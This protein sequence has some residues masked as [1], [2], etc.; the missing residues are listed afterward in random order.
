MNLA[1]DGSLGAPPRTP[2]GGAPPPGPRHNFLFLHGWGFDALVWDGVRARLGGVAPDLG[3]LGAPVPAPAE[4]DAR[5]IAVGHSLGCL[6]LLGA[7]P[8]GCVG[9][10]AVNGFSRFC[11]APDFPNGVPTRLLERMLA[12]LET[13]PYAVLAEFRHRC[14]APPL[15]AGSALDAD[16][17]ERLRAGLLALR[18]RDE[19]AAA[20]ALAVPMLVLAGEADPI[21]PPALTQASFPGRTI[22]WRAGGGHLLPL[23]DPDWCA[24]RIAAFAAPDP[25]NVCG[26]GGA[27]PQRGAGQRPAAS[28][29]RCV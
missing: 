10:I 15:Q 20:G 8:P 28:L 29:K 7:L 24:E 22:L 21:A 26:S 1:T 2:P 17:R 19:R 9:F 25:L 5:V 6:L 4:P 14:G 3:Y 23:T 11:A 18:D 16:R 12:R 13:E 27:R